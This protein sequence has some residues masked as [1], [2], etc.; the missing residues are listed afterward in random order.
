MKVEIRNKK[1]QKCPIELV[2]SL[3]LNMKA[4]F[5]VQGSMRLMIQKQINNELKQKKWF[6]SF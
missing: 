2:E 3:Y 4:Q 6:L 1:C 5:K